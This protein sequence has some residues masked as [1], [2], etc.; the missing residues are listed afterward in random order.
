MTPSVDAILDSMEESM[1]QV[2]ADFE[3]HGTLVACVERGLKLC[4]ASNVASK[5][6]IH[7]KH[8][9]VS[10]YNR[11][12]YGINGGDVHDLGGDIAEVGFSFKK[13]EDAVNLQITPGGTE[14]AHNVAMVAQA[15]GLLAAVEPCTLTH[16]S[17]S[18]GHL[19]QLL[20]AVH[21]E[22]PTEK[23]CLAVDGKMSLDKIKKKDANFGLAVESG[24]DWLELHWKVGQRWPRFIHMV[25]AEGN[26]GAQLQR[27]EHELQVS[28][29]IHRELLGMERA[30]C[31]DKA[32][33]LRNVVRSK[34]PCKDYVHILLK[35][36][37]LCGGGENGQLLQGLCRFQKLHCNTK[38]VLRGD[39]LQAIYSLDLGIENMCVL[40][41]IALCKAALQCPE[42]HVK[43]GVARWITEQYVK[44]CA[45]NAEMK[46]MVWRADRILGACRKIAAEL[47]SADGSGPKVV[48]AQLLGRLDVRMALFVLGKSKQYSTPEDIGE[49]FLDDL[50]EHLALGS[51]SVRQIREASP[52]LRHDK[53]ASESEAPKDNDGKRSAAMLQFAPDGSLVDAAAVI[54]RKGFHE[55]EWVVDKKRGGVLRIAK[56]DGPTQTITLESEGGSSAQ[57]V[58]FQEFLERFRIAPESSV[59]KPDDVADWMGSQPTHSFELEAM[60]LKHHYIAGAARLY[61]VHAKVQDTLKIVK[62]PTKRVF[63]KTALRVGQV[64]IVPATTSVAIETFSTD[65]E[66]RQHAC[67]KTNAAYFA[68][69]A[70]VLDKQVAILL[71]PSVHI[72]EEQQ[73]TKKD[74]PN[75]VCPFWFVRNVPK[76][77][78]LEEEQVVVQHTLDVKILGA[79]PTR[80]VV[81]IPTYTNRVAL[82]PGDELTIGTPKAPGKASSSSS[83]SRAMAAPVAKRGR[84]A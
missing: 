75:F 63:A 71:K 78:T 84:K 53:A 58:T 35:F 24:L 1:Q 4:V 65:A 67:N 52:L 54:S 83:S 3:K 33:L 37:E 46:A 72:Q 45:S 27:V 73:H 11:D 43:N 12:E 81:S 82:Q 38:L 6:R 64:H 41:R 16:L 29:R 14:E 13:C 19:N 79:K 49:A 20:R 76:N 77:A 57:S 5:I 68:G 40:F 17:C 23:E 15:G 21:Y 51:D 34:P 9:G 30:G 7:C 61:A 2:L 47:P 60:I 26:T 28:L 59:P 25:V 8:V 44:S 69:Q 66:L 22:V 36:V 74:C 48:M 55:G 18:K 39:F 50:V 62:A 10:P 70:T 42:T 32:K 31:V 56:T 80:V